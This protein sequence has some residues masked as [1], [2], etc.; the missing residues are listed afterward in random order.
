MKRA[1][2]EAAN[3]GQDCGKKPKGDGAAG[4]DG[5]AAPDRHVGDES[6][7]VTD[8]SAQPGQPGTTFADALA[9]TLAEKGADEEDEEDDD[10]D[11]DYTFLSVN[12]KRR[13]KRGDLEGMAR[14]AAVTGKPS[15]FIQFDDD[16]GMAMLDVPET[17]A[18]LPGSGDGIAMS[19]LILA[20]LGDTHMEACYREDCHRDMIFGN[21]LAGREFPMNLSTTMFQV[22]EKR[23]EATGEVKYRELMRFL[24][25][26]GKVEAFR[27]PDHFDPDPLHRQTDPPQVLE[28]EALA[29]KYFPGIQTKAQT[30]RS[31]IRDTGRGGSSGLLP[32]IRFVAFL[33][34]SCV[35][36]LL[37]GS[38]RQDGV[39]FSPNQDIVEFNEDNFGDRASHGVWAYHELFPYYR[40]DAYRH[41]WTPAGLRKAVIEVAK[42]PDLRELPGG[43]RLLRGALPW[44]M[45][46]HRFF[47]P[48]ERG[49][50]RDR[51][52][53]MV[54][55][56]KRVN[57]IIPGIIFT[58][59]IMPFLGIADPPFRPTTADL[60]SSYPVA[61]PPATLAEFDKLAMAGITDC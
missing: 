53:A 1:G 26:Y 29:Q 44:S 13:I 22:A 60:R 38:H 37:T 3:V 39:L 8:G 48:L 19:A 15:E 47:D 31:G 46:T 34:A 28:P 52:F 2:N 58:D 11:R 42:R 20:L 35:D 54:I 36:I 21:E 9:D 27:K 17:I 33:P 43:R 30:C 32:A 41:L 16:F 18:S 49:R 61:Y 59:K 51:F 45:A 50:I 25:T 7:V 23:F 12:L 56:I 5:A 57:P 24:M 10:K 40:M 4:G 14:L 55:S 6:A